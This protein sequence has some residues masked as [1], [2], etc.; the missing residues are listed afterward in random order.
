MT[1]RPVPIFALACALAAC[2]GESHP[3]ERL[4]AWGLF[5]D[6]AAQR[7]ADGVVPYEVI[8]PLF[9]DYA[10]KHR[11]IRVPEG[12]TITYTSEG[13]WEF[14]IG[15][16]L[17]KTFGFL[18]DLRDPSAGEDI[19]ETRLLVLEEDGE[20]HPYV[21]VW[22]DAA[23]DALLTQAGASVPVAWTH[24][25]GSRRELVYRV[26]NAVQCANCHGGRRAPTPIGPRTEQLDR[27][28]DYGAGPENQIDHLVSLGWLAGDVPPH[29]ER[30]RFEDPEGEGDLEARARA[31]LDA[32]CAHCHNEDG[33]ASQSGLW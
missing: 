5:A 18:A 19:V 33:A 13:D 15:T 7:P 31:Y 27:D 3:P 23:S 4:S 26:P 14:P 16:V 30:P 32:N 2:A 28:Y 24:T 8:A 20:W 22:D 1:R 9:S 12:E 25:D 21:Y 17:V 6:G 10:A 29:G 11:F